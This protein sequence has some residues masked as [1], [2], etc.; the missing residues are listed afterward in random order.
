MMY[1]L[2]GDAYTFLMFQVNPKFK[3]FRNRDLSIYWDHYSTL[4]G[5]VVANGNRARAANTYS[6]VNLEI[7][8]DFTETGEDDGREGSGDSDD[9]HQSPQ[10][11]VLFPNSS[12]KSGRS[13][14]TKRKKSG[15]EFV[16]EGLDGLVAAMS[17]RSTS[18]TAANEDVTLMEAVGI[19]KSMTQVPY[20]GDLYYFAQR[21]LLNKGNRL[22]FL[23]EQNDELRYGQLMYNFR[24][25]NKA[26]GKQSAGQFGGDSGCQ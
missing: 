18:T 9:N 4:F 3:K 25:N 15:A 13:S 5:D 6:A 10:S 14:G 26:A 17:C 22:L 8:E 24:L 2:V 21:Y 23:S 11:N 1:I 7:G 20:G 12:L 19:L 16:R